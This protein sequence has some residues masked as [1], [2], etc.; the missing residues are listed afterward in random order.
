MLPYDPEQ[1][2]AASYTPERCDAL[3]RAALED[4]SQPFEVLDVATWVMTAQVARAL[5]R[6]PGLPRG[7]R[8]APVPARPVGWVST[9]VSP[10]PTTSCG[11]SRRSR[12]AAR[13]PGCSTPTSPSVGRSRCA[14]PRRACPTRCSSS[15]CRSRWVRTTTS[16]WPRPTWRRPWPTRKGAPRWSPRSSTRPRTSTCWGCS[17][18]TRYGSEQQGHGDGFDPIRA[19]PAVQPGRR[20]TAARLAPARRPDLFEPRPRPPGSQRADR[21]SDM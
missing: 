17:W 10:T 2:D 12:L 5:P 20:P 8:R 14:T 9:P 13:R 15:R 3:V 19:L 4:P 21:R 18:A 16:T 7:R 1:E 11:S 6:G